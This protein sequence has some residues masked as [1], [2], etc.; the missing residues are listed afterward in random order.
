LD[1]IL[2]PIG[3]TQRACNVSV[4]SPDLASAYT[5]RSRPRDGSSRRRRAIAVG[6]V[7]PT[8]TSNNDFRLPTGMTKTSN[9]D[10]SAAHAATVRL[11]ES[12]AWAECEP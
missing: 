5:A 9:D 1:G 4:L 11:N 10:T 12:R 8:A 7:R 3:D 6:A 2:T